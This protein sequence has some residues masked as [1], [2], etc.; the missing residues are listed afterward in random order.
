[1]YITE[2]CFSWSMCMY[3]S[4][5]IRVC[6]YVRTPP[7]SASHL[8]RVC[9]YVCTSPR[10]ASHCPCVCTCLT[11]YVYVCMCVHHRRLLLVLYVYVCMCVHPPLV[12]VV[13]M[14]DSVYVISSSTLLLCTFSTVYMLS[15]AQRCCCVHDRQCTCM[16]VCVYITDVCFSYCTCMYVCVYITDVCFSLSMCMYM[17][18]S[19]RLCICH[20]WPVYFI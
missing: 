13:Y 11:V 7:R 20:T 17:S 16:Y 18:H 6:M 3:M 12:V 19:I 9:M 1:V 10:S 5:S 15:V 2:V 14:T 4:H 8:V